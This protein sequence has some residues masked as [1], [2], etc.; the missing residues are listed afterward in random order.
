MSTLHKV[1]RALLAMNNACGGTTDPAH[2]VNFM[3]I[4]VYPSEYF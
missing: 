2:K 3:Q 4:G 1:Q